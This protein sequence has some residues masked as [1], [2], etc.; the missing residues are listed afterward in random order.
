MLM[1]PSNSSAGGDGTARYWILKLLIDSFR[2]G[3]PAGTTAPAEADVLVATNT[4]GAGRS[5]SSP[6]CAE[7]INL[8]TLKMYCATGIINNITFADY[9]TPTGTCGSWAVNPACSAVNGS[10]IVREACVGRTSCSINTDTPTFGDPC[11][12]VVKRLVVEATCST[13]GG[14]QIVP[15]AVYAQAFVEG[16]G[17]GGRKALV[18]N[19]DAS[20]H[21]VTLAGAAG[22]SWAVVDASTGYGPAATSALEADTWLLAPFAAGVLR[23]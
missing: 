22:G 14:A 20:P 12:G 1:W 11:F 17:G 6:F 21:N 23:L 10:T 15:P 2:A 19:M 9:G 18:V 13:G 8:S 7:Q 16:G 4:S 5:I 3:P